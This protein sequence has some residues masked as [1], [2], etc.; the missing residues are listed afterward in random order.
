MSPPQRLGFDF[1]C[2]GSF[3]S[4]HQLRECIVEIRDVVPSYPRLPILSHSLP[5]KE[6]FR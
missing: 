1:P 4:Y 3:L 2:D 6:V 5:A